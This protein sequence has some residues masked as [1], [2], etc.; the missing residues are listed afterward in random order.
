MFLQ[1]IPVTKMKTSK[2]D[3]NEVVRLRQLG[4]TQKEIAERVGVTQQAISLTLIKSR[5]KGEIGV[6]I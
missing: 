4:Y 5:T 3:I 1:Y 6:A 2:I